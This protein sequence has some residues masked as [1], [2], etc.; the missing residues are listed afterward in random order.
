MSE[1]TVTLDVCETIS[2]GGDPFARIMRAADA[3]APRQKLRVIAPFKPVP[4]LRVMASKGFTHQAEPLG[5][6]GNWQVVFERRPAPAAS[7]ASAVASDEAD[8]SP[9]KACAST[10]T[11]EVDAR[12]LEPPEPMVK[13]LE[14]VEALPAGAELKARTDRR[15][16]HLFAHLEFRGCVGTAEEQEDGSYVTTIRRT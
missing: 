9:A 14:A 11:V 1:S 13:I 2:G 6:S 3:L 4:L 16:M 10:P 5:D 12:G 7:P 15:P 8:G